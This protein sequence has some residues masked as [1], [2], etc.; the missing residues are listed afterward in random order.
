MNFAENLASKRW[1]IAPP[2]PAEIARQLNHIHPVLQQVLYNRGLTS[3]GE[4]QAFLE[5]QYLLP[6]DPF[7]LADMEAA[8]ERIVEA[9]RDDERIV[10]YGDFDC[11]GVTATVL[12]TEAL[13]GLGFGRDQVRP[14]IPDR[15]DEGYGLNMDALS[16]IR[17]EYEASLVI[18]VDCG[19]RANI[20]AAH[21][22]A[23][24]LDLIITDHHSLGASLPPAAAVINPK[25]PDSRYPEEMLAGVGIAYKLA[26]A[27]QQK[28]PGSLELENLLDLVAI[29]TVADVTPLLGENRLLVRRG[30]EVL[31]RLRRPGLAALAETAGLR[32][33][34]ITAESIGFAIGPRL[35]A[36]GRIGPQTVEYRRG[37][38]VVSRPG[39][40]YIAAYLLT[41]TD[42][43]EGRVWAD[44]LN[45]LNR[46]RQSL[47]TQLNSQAEAQIEDPT[48]APIL[49]AADPN[50][51]PGVI[52]LV[53][54]RLKETYY[55]PSVVIEVGETESHGSC[56]SIPEFHIT[57]ALDQVAD[58]LERYGGHAQA[59]GLTIRN[60]KL[61]AFR[62]RMTELAAASLAGVE[63]RPSL[64]ID[65]PLDLAEVDWALH[66]ILSGLEPTGCANAAPLFISRGV[67]VLHHRAVGRDG[68]HLQMEFLADQNRSLQGIGFG[69][70]AWANQMRTHMD[71]VFAI[72][73]N[74]WKGRKRLQLQIQ[75]ISP[76]HPTH[77]HDSRRN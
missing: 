61:P 36:A 20:E 57:E 17:S 10:I 21:A 34:Q 75:D 27:L 50:F 12:L 60:E 54:G 76:A 8:V 42:L 11:D 64:E 70:G 68:A 41:A 72:S 48:S 35:N 23:I 59:A 52:G 3:Q 16:R 56:R 63:L 19:I 49:I 74:E 14:Y 30:L 7:L 6:D 15:V 4:I 33:G 9:L 69:L 5:G 66:D 26:C 73:S 31:N 32:P 55:R 1:E 65:M 43:F 37:D 45:A 39:H 18:T 44:R 25:R 51:Q 28:L 77:A 13:R 38:R 47:T 29:G 46:Q 53:A 67:E 22:A 71:I 24:G 40:A 58:L 62:E 2:L